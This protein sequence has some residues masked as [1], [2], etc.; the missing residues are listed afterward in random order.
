MIK[1]QKLKL[2]NIVKKKKLTRRSSFDKSCYWND[3]SIYPTKL[4]GVTKLFM[5]LVYLLYRILKETRNIRIQIMR[6]K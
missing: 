1:K 2:V 3:H 6:R 5:I 4:L